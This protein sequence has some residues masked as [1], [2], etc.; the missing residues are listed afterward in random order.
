LQAYSP[1]GGGEIASGKVDAV[2]AVANAHN[3]SAAQVALRW[4][5]QQGVAAIPKASTTDYQLENMDV[6]GFELNASEMRTLSVMTNP[7]GN[8]Q[9]QDPASMMCIDE[10]A[11]R[12]A[13][14][15]YLE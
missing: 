3:V 13:R 14:C 7:P 2:N 9:N 1:L 12:M 15:I 8:G 5:V 4:I 11:G 10:D 6:F